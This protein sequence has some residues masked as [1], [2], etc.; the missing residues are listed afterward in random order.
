ME[1]PSLPGTGR[2]GAVAGGQELDDDLLNAT[3]AESLR[4]QPWA[5]CAY[6]FGTRSSSSARRSGA[7][8][9]SGT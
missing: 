8:G 3:L 2:G 4:D 9:A 7:S 1:R 6:S 5:E